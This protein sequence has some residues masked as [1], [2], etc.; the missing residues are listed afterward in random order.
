MKFYR[1][2]FKNYAEYSRYENYRSRAEPL[3]I[4]THDETSDLCPRPPKRKVKPPP[5]WRP[6]PYGYPRDGR[7]KSQRGY[8]VTAEEYDESEDHHD[9]HCAAASSSSCQPE[10]A[11]SDAGHSWSWRAQSWNDWKESSDDRQVPYPDTKRWG[12][13]RK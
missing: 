13:D 7:A 5:K 1:E 3:V 11:A 8:Y 9:R 10:A 12:T 6:N 4:D 2:D